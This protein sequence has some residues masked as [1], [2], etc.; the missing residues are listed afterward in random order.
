[1]GDDKHDV[2]DNLINEHRYEK[3]IVPLDRKNNIFHTRSLY[4][5]EF[6]QRIS[7]GSGIH[8]IVTNNGIKCGRVTNFEKRKATY[9]TPAV[10]TFKSVIFWDSF[11]ADD[12]EI[13]NN[14]GK[15]VG[16][17]DEKR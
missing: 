6:V 16:M 7:K 2:T 17:I 15:G 3:A 5:S 10:E 13:I 11:D 1:M 8:V 4:E 12:I 14:D 9:P